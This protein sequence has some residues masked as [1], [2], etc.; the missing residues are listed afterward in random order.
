MLVNACSSGLTA[1]YTVP[2]TAGAE[3][4]ASSGDVVSL[5]ATAPTEPTLK[6]QAAAVPASPYEAPEMAALFPTADQV[7]A[8]YRVK[9]EDNPA[10]WLVNGEVRTA[11]NARPVYSQVAI[12]QGGEL[13]PVLLGYEPVLGAADAAE[14]VGSAQKAWNHGMGSWPQLGPEARIAA[15]EKFLTLIEANQDK[16]A[17]LLQWEIGK[18]ISSSKKEIARTVQFTREKI[19]EYRGMLGPGALMAGK[20]GSQMHYA[21]SQP[22]PK[23]V[24]LSVGP[25]NYPFNESWSSIMPALLTGN[26]VM[27]KT[28]RFGMLSNMALARLAA[29][30]FPAGALQIIP[31]DGRAV[32]P[33]IMKATEELPGIGKKGVVD[34][35]AFIGSKRAYDAI[36]AAHPTPDTLSRSSGLGAKNA[37]VVLPFTGTPDEVAAQIKDV[38][39]QIVKGGLGFNGQRC[40]AEKIVLVHESQADQLAAAIREEVGK[41]KVDMPWNDP[42]IS[43]LPEPTKLA[44][45]RAYLEDAASKGATVTGGEG[46]FSLMKPA[47]VY[48]VDSSMRIYHEE[49]FGPIVPIA[50]FKDIQ[51][52]YDYHEQSPFGQQASIFGPPGQ[53]G[54]VAQYLLDREF[55]ARTNENTTCKRGPDSFVFTARRQSGEGECGALETYLKPQVRVSV[56]EE[57]F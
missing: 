49:Q 1:N 30:C 55:V 3:K 12:N 16:L 18:P 32:L 17:N 10:V 11:A 8:R 41:L 34:H 53:T 56:R 50:V 42:A 5:G 54:A 29:Q 46:T 26:V 15:V 27:A 23:G 48:P 57:D 31:G 38:A 19:E 20:E 33:E 2:R 51:E 45:M 40:T 24:V 39:G 28:P 22:H 52:V 44:D 43:P 21:Q 4:P 7:P 37:A 25:F 47:V 6:P 13:K 14:A 35:F 9:P 36:R